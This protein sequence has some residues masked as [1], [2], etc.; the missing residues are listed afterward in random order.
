MPSDFLQMV[1]ADL[2]ELLEHELLVFGADAD[3][4]VRDR[5]LDAAV[6]ALGAHA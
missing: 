3:A 5:D 1:A 2:P 4:G 6:G